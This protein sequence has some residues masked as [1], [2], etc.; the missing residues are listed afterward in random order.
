[1]LEKSLI[2]LLRVGF[3]Y[4]LEFSFS[5]RHS[6][7]INRREKMK[8]STSFLVVL[9]YSVAYLNQI[10]I[11]A[12]VHSFVRQA[13]QPH[14]LSNQYGFHRLEKASQQ[15]KQ[16][17]DITLR[18]ALLALRSPDDFKGRMASIQYLSIS[19]IF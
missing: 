16:P 19:T 10:T 4:L 8:F 15:L 14:W 11:E 5:F 9:I 2:F 18:S 1:M 3:S 17:E 13:N 7:I 6:N 12:K